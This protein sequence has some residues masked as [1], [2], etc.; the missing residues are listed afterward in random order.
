M[1]TPTSFH[2]EE[3][4]HKKKKDKKEKKSKKEKKEHKSRKKGEAIR[5]AFDPGTIPSQNHHSW[6]K[7]LPSPSRQKHHYDARRATISQADS[8]TRVGRTKSV[9]VRSTATSVTPTPI[10]PE[11]TE[12]GQELAAFVARIEPSLKEYNL[13]LHKTFIAHVEY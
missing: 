11:I 2:V 3:K 12:N 10:F 9:I 13:N 7:A 6:S 8:G 1:S 4:N 5:P